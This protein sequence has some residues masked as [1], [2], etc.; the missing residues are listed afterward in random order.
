MSAKLSQNPGP[1]YTE[2]ATNYPNYNSK[3]VTIKDIKKEQDKLYIILKSIKRQA[4]K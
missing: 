3:L 1:S 2:I 4:F